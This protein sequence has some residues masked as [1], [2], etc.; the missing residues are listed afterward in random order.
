LRPTDPCMGEVLSGGAAPFFNSA[1]CV[2]SPKLSP[3]PPGEAE[4]GRIVRGLDW[5]SQCLDPLLRGQTERFGCGRTFRPLLD[6]IVTIWKRLWGESL[7]CRMVRVGVSQCL[8]GGWRKRQGTYILGSSCMHY[9][10]PGVTQFSYG[11]VN[12][13]ASVLCKYIVPVLPSSSFTS[14]RTIFRY[15]NVN[16]VQILIHNLFK[17]SLRGLPFP[18]SALLL[19]TV[20]CTL[21]TPRPCLQ[22]S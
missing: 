1:I 6:Q 15:L 20:R 11:W 10:G 7:Q 17:F 14:L 22:R 2:S 12:S 13:A 8:N 18:V 19:C 5:H 16:C 4:N 3:N 9:P 21:C